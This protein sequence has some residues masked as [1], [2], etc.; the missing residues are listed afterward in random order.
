MTHCLKEPGD[1]AHRSLYARK[2]AIAAAAVK[3]IL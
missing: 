2:M 1:D 3:V